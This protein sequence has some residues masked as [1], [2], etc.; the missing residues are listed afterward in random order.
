LV[1]T[2]V[3]ASA[4]TISGVAGANELSGDLFGNTFKQADRQIVV[5]QEDA[6]AAAG[7]EPV[8]KACLKFAADVDADLGEVLKAG[9]KPTLAQMSAL[10]DNPLGNVAMLYT[11]VDYYN[12]SNDTVNT[13]TSKDQFV[14]TGIAQFPKKLNDDW[15]LINRVIWT[16][17]SVPVDQDKIDAIGGGGFQPGTPGAPGSGPLIDLIGGRTTGFGDT[18]YLGLF[19]PNEGADMLDGKF[20]WG[21]GFDIALPTGTEDVLTSNKWSAGPSALAVYM[22][23]TWK[24]G[25]LLMQYWSFAGD[26]FDSNGQ[27]VPDVNTTNLQYFAFYSLNH[28]SSIGAS[29]NII[30][31]WEADS[32]NKV[33][34][35]IGIGYVSTVKM[36]KVPV[37]IGLEFHYNVIRPDDVGANYGIRFYVIPAA[38]S[39]LFDWMG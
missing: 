15:N 36:G 35:P 27:P 8:S 4:F 12:L 20:L 13:G 23:P 22:G 2:L 7:S 31:D 6:A 37:R 32:G 14:Y 19:A 28:T 39:A 1:S 38:P 21:A 5:A 25:G 16:V 18:Y 24:L 9:C 3:L 10:M 30:I 17:P 33:T 34:L 29:P 26:D 11:Q